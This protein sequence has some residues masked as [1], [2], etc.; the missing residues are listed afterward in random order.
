MFLVACHTYPKLIDT[1]S[2][3]EY[4]GKVLATA[5]TM[6]IERAAAIAQSA[7]LSGEFISHN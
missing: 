6:P 7:D 4:H 1:T 5:N 3:P 2:R